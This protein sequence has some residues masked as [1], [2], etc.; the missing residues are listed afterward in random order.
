MKATMIFLSGWAYPS[1]EYAALSARLASH[2]EVRFFD[3]RSFPRY[4]DDVCA[5]VAQ[6][7][8]PVWLAG[9]S[10]G[11]II[12][13]QVAHRMPDALAGLILLASTPCFC[14][15]EDFSAGTPVASVRALAKTLK[16]TPALAMRTFLKMAVKP[17][18]L[19]KADLERRVTNALQFDKDMLQA[20]L[21]YLETTDIRG[22]VAAITTPTLLI[23][24]EDDTIIP[25]E[26]GHW[27]HRHIPNSIPAFLSDTGHDLPVTHV[28]ATADI[29]ISFKEGLS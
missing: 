11:S 19:G 23:H 21:K 8:E 2:V 29:M 12:A 10:M 5:L 15:Q 26:A 13:L 24:G 3:H 28:A 25:L 16:V 9:W 18:K 17:A 14:A 7:D 1:D 20:G 27:L 22:D 4:D 6:A